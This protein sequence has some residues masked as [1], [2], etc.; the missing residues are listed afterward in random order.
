MFNWETAS[1]ITDGWKFVYGLGFMPLAFPIKDGQ[2]KDYEKTLVIGHPGE[3]WG[4]YT[5]MA[6]FN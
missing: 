2:D 6:G 5:G 1:G 3:D 4:S